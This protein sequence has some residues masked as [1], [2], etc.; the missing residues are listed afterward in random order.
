MTRYAGRGGHNAA[1]DMVG[2]RT[3]GRTGDTRA[4]NDANKREQL[5]NM[6]KN[7]PTRSIP[8][9]EQPSGKL[10]VITKAW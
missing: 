10:T 5:E 9:I 3:K 8:V 7:G 1:R 4:S 6:F 2:R